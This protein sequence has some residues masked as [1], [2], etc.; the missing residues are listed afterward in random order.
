MI[1]TGTSLSRC[2]SK[3]TSCP[4]VCRW[5]NDASGGFVLTLQ[6]W[7]I[8]RQ[9]RSVVCQDQTDVPSNKSHAPA[10]TSVFS[11][12]LKTCSLPK[13]I[14]V[15]VHFQENAQFRY[16]IRIYFYLWGIKVNGHTNRGFLFETYMLSMCMQ[17]WWIYL[18]V[19]VHNFLSS[20]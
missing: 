15:W 2:F 7:S 8:L 19:I 20:R 12:I 4:G 17:V 13:I 10:Q 11:G 16:L 18:P 1:L 5:D 14:Y 3:L 9:Q 6:F